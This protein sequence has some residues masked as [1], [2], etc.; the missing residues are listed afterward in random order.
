V[1]I[2]TLHIPFFKIHNELLFTMKSSLIL[3]SVVSGASAFAPSSKH[4]S[5]SVGLSAATGEWEEEEAKVYPTINGWTADPTKF[6]AG[7]PGAISPL[8][9]FDPLGFTTDLPIQEIKRFRE[10][11][12]THGRVAMLAVVGYLV[13]E[14]FHPFFNG[15][16]TGPANTHLTQVHEIAPFFFAWLG[17]SIAT[18]ELFRANVG[19]EFPTDAISKNAAMKEEE[20][21]EGK[22]F[23]AKLNDQYYP[24]DLKFDPLGLKPKDPT[25]FANMQTKELQNGRLAMIAAMGMIVQEQVTHH[26]LF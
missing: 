14:P 24:G 12:V 8:G 22:T 10:A 7:L 6:C 25:E 16:V 3:L 21:F 19:W 2:A 23:L 5:N 20:N 9:N 13:Q 11:E 4:S 15:L 17:G 26:T 18:A 1:L